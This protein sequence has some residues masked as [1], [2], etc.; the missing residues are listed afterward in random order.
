MESL[1]AC[2]TNYYEQVK[3]DLETPG[4]LPATH[5]VQIKG[6]PSPLWPWQRGGHQ[7]FANL[8]FDPK[9]KGSKDEALK[10]R[11]AINLTGT[12][13]Y[14]R[15]TIRIETGSKSLNVDVILMTRPGAIPNHR[16][17]LTCFGIRALAAKRI[18]EGCEENPDGGP[19]QR[20]M[21][22]CG[23]N[24]AAYDYPGMGANETDSI[25]L[26]NCVNAHNGIVAFVQQEKQPEQLVL[27][28][29]S[30]GAY[31]ISEAKKVSLPTIPSIS[32]FDR[33]ARRTT[34][35]LWLDGFIPYFFGTTLGWDI[36]ID[37]SQERTIF[38]T[39]AQTE[40]DAL[41]EPGDSLVP[42]DTAM[43]TE[44]NLAWYALTFLKK[45]VIGHNG[46]HDCTCQHWR[47]LS[48]CLERAFK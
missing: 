45:E 38:M 23:T 20:L 48:E 11:T 24:I 46:W 35:I 21:S 19:L 42:T 4:L 7:W 33:A 10:A 5:T 1:Q 26:E 6:M 40:Q 39:N 2:N 12:T 13:L 41:F 25:S 17:T 47:V 18:A 44:A 22:E 9:G 31:I 14:E 34:D 29:H 36:A 30:V 15:K 27:Y 32:V 28:G 37:P 43:K 8:M 3:Q 16:W